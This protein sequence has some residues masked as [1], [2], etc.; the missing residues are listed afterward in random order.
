MPIQPLL[1]KSKI[2]QKATLLL[3]DKVEQLRAVPITDLNPG[4]YAES[5]N[6]FE[7]QWRIEAHTPFMGTSQIRCRV[8]YSPTSNTVVET[9]FYRSE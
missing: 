8:I 1:H 6:R 3:L 9:L 2:N 4:E 5:R 7:I